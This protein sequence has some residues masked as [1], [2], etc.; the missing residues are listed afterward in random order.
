MVVVDV[1]VVEVALTRVVDVVA[2]N[3]VVDTTSVVVELSILGVDCGLHAD[4]TR[5]KPTVAVA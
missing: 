5:S 1:E 3:V 4:T 2:G